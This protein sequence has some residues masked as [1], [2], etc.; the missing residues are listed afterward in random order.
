MI[1]REE[2]HAC[3]TP[4]TRVCHLH[5]RVAK[6]LQTRCRKKVMCIHTY[7]CVHTFRV[8]T[9]ISCMFTHFVCVHTFRVCTHISCVQIFRRYVCPCSH[10]I[11]H[12][13][14]SYVPSRRDDTRAFDLPPGPACA[15]C[16][17]PDSPHS[18][19]PTS[20]LSAHEKPRTVSSSLLYT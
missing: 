3:A 2:I 19:T 8:C 17:V 16:I 5:A 13:W 6:S 10:N 11:T 1:Q 15:C 9:H 18:S 4:V 12:R 14:P 7:L 20:P